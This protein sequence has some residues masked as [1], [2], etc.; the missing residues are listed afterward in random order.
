[1]PSYVKFNNL[2]SNALGQERVSSA[3]KRV[4]SSK[5]KQLEIQLRRKQETTTK[6]HANINDLMSL[7]EYGCW[8]LNAKISILF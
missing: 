4:Q 5:V 3:N 1:M 6:N 2:S 8:L 7:L